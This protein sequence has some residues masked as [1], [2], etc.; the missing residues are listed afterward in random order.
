VARMDA[1]DICMPQRLVRQ[2]EYLRAHPDVAVLG[3]AVTF[4]GEGKVDFVGY[5][6][7][8]HDEIKCALLYGYTMLHPSVMI[9]RAEFEKHGLNYDPAFRVSQDHDLWVR[10]IRKVRF[11]NLH[12]SLLQLRLHPAKIGS[13]HSSLQQELSDVVRHLQLAELEIAASTHELSIFVG[14]SAQ[15]E[16]WTGEDCRM[17]EALLLRIFS[18][19]A[20]LSMYAQDVLVRMGVEH[21]RGICRQLLVAGNSSGRYYWRSALRRIDRPSIRNFI[22]LAYR[23]IIGVHM[24]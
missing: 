19:N 9:R 23:S 18:A 16:M 13:T 8:E 7:L 12:E 10:A 5:Q 11:A 24:Q 2:V 3:S 1:D 6:P 21:F 14:P 4:F 20:A 17:L 22:G 15:A